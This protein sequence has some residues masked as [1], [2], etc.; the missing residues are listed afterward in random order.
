MIIRN[1][2]I[3]ARLYISFGV[4]IFIFVVFGFNS[5]KDF[6]ELRSVTEE[7]ESN[8]VPSIVV[9]NDIR[10]EYSQMKY[11]MFKYY[12]L[13]E[14]QRSLH[15][16]QL[17]VVYDSFLE[18]V[19]D[20]SGLIS[21]P[22]EQEKFNMLSESVTKF[23]SEIL[24]FFESVDNNYNSEL[25]SDVIEKNN[26]FDK[27][28]AYD[29]Q[30]FGLIGDISKINK[31]YAV[32]ISMKSKENY[33]LL[34]V[35]TCVFILLM[36]LF[37][38][39]LSVLITRSIV[40]PMVNIVNV[41]DAISKNDLTSEVDQMYESGNDEIYTLSR[42][43][44]KMKENL[45]KIVMEVSLSS[46]GLLQA[47]EKLNL[48]ID[49][50]SVRLKEQDAQ[51][52]QAATAVT[53]MCTSIDE[54][55]KMAV[56][57]SHGSN[58]AANTVVEG[59]DDLS[60]TIKS[61][62]I[63]EHEILS[64]SDSINSLF[65]KTTDVRQVVNVI[66]NISEQ[67]SLLALNA[68]IEAARAGVAGH[69]FAVVAEEVRALAARTQK[70][71]IVID[72]IIEDICE[73]AKSSVNLVDNC[74]ARVSEVLKMA[75]LTDVALN[76]IN[77]QVLNINESNLII[78]SAAEEQSKVSREIDANIINICDISKITYGASSDINFESERLV[79]LANNLSLLV[80]KFKLQ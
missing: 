46:K 1:V 68:A 77:N 64:A 23:Y 63:M 37:S 36:V 42:S 51:I 2:H 8:T 70:S 29:D 55:A 58:S 31:D 19:G 48:V 80:E 13:N 52:F 30:V 53:Q 22:G 4:L 66:R 38:V 11:L 34:F 24:I 7:I 79:A 57:S 61:I 54:V 72:K 3:G 71:T 33:D 59:K 27:L 14:K 45:C 73:E 10:A 67:I 69:G 9:V 6:S 76:N 65:E 78:A 41:V 25:V 40:K 62:N 15:K 18:S 50:N 60:R 35:K 26:F 39:G 74:T 47:S 16:N 44:Y 43:V 12:F 5:L 49:G 75:N 56:N 20:Y 17:N 21:L 32:Q 28:S